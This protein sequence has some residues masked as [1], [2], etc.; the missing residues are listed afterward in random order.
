L[1]IIRNKKNQHKNQK[2]TNSIQ[3]ADPTGDTGRLYVERK[4]GRMKGLVTN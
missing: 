3:I 4:E 2:G 1:K